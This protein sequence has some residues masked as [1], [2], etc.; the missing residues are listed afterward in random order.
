[1]KGNICIFFCSFTTV[2][3]NFFCSFTTVGLNS[4]LLRIMYENKIGNKRAILMLMKTI[5]VKF[6]QSFFLL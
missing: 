1:M 4:L 2:G 6:S 3:I 5:E